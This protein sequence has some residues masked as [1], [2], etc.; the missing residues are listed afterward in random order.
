MGVGSQRDSGPSAS[1]LRAASYLG[2]NSVGILR[3]IVAYLGEACDVEIRFDDAAPRTSADATGGQGVDLVWACG[4]LTVELM[5]ARELDTEIVAAPVF[6]GQADAVYHSVLVCRADS[7]FTALADATGARLAINET[8]SWSGHH[9]LVAHLASEGHSIEMFG[10]VVT[11]GSHASS[12][13][14]VAS[15]AADLAA[16]DHTVWD[17]FAD[18]SPEHGLVA[19]GRTSDWPAPPFSLRRSLDPD[20][21]VRLANALTSIGPDEIEGLTR[22]ISTTRSNYQFML[23]TD[24]Q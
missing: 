20:L 6:E 1:A 21:R 14:A 2:D 17:Q 15:G 18:N 3:G 13:A 10:T 8:E 19:F 23:P 4:L 22:I 7:R 24:S 5:A 16:I 11:T 9:G 12:V